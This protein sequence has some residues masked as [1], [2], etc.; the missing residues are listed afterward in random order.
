[1]LG[2]KTQSGGPHSIRNFIGGAAIIFIALMF[3]PDLGASHAQGSLKSKGNTQGQSLPGPL[4]HSDQIQNWT[5]ILHRGYN[6]DFGC[7]ILRLNKIDGPNGETS[8]DTC[9]QDK[10]DYDSHP[11]GSSYQTKGEWLDNLNGPHDNSTEERP[12]D[13]PV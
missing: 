4:G 3:T 9:A 10:K 11:D 1:M 2:R 6:D 7:W 8:Q 13:R 5:V 12:A